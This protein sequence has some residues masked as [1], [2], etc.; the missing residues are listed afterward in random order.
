MFQTL[1]SRF[2][3]TFLVIFLACFGVG[4]LAAPGVALAADPQTVFDHDLTPE[5][6]AV[7]VEGQKGQMKMG[8]K[9]AKAPLSK[10]LSY[11]V[12]DVEDAGVRVVRW[13]VRANVLFAWAIGMF[14]VAFLVFAVFGDAPYEVPKE[15]GTLLVLDLLTLIGNYYW[16]WDFPWTL[17]IPF[18]VIDALIFFAGLLG[19]DGRW[20]I[21]LAFLRLGTVVLVL[22][23]IFSSAVG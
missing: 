7:V 13:T 23:E 4:F 21:V 1:V 2:R 14:L 3:S 8:A 16:D 17:W 11:R 6:R 22:Y 19:G 15:A 12:A 9:E 18:F 10:R 5:K 20:K